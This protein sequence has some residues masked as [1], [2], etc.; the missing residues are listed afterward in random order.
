MRHAYSTHISELAFLVEQAAADCE[1]LT[2]LPLSQDVLRRRSAAALGAARTTGGA[3]PSGAPEQPPASSS[4][5]PTAEE[6]QRALDLA[7]GFVARA[8][9]RLGISRH[10]LNRLIRRHQL[11]I[12]RGAG[13]GSD[14]ARCSDDD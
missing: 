7:S 3:P 6:A 11:T 14:G 8:A 5:L 2:L 12:S 1:G 4:F 13:S 9:V 10:Q